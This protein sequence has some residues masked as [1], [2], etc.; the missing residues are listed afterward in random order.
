MSVFVAALTSTIALSGCATYG[1]VGK[2]YHYRKIKL[3]VELP[4]GWLRFNQAKA[5]YL[6]TCDGLGL[7]AIGIH[8]T[9]MGKKLPDTQRVYRA[10]MLPHEL[11]ELTL[12]LIEARDETNEFHVDNIEL[13]DIAEHDGYRADVVFKDENGLRKRLRIYGAGIEGYLCEF[14]YEAADEVYFDKYVDIFEN[15]ASSAT[16]RKSRQ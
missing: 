8:V 9:R 16:I 2:T 5:A 11:A 14:R 6:M 4:S 3:E 13:S 10:D 12:S 15:L 7:D 1:P